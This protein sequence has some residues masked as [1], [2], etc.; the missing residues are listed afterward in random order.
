MRGSWK[1]QIHSCNFLKKFYGSSKQ[2]FSAILN[3]R[4]HSWE[5]IRCVIYPDDIYFLFTLNCVF[6]SGLRVEASWWPRWGDSSWE[7]MK[8]IIHLRWLG[9]WMLLFFSIGDHGRR[10]ILLWG[11]TADDFMR[12]FEDNNSMF[13]GLPRPLVDFIVKRCQ[14]F[15][16]PV[17]SLGFLEMCNQR[18]PRWSLTMIKC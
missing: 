18:S 10:K 8:L 14:L 2:V 11:N 15:E 5:E 9:Y 3:P 1:G 17:L 6:T 12:A 16:P 13:S 4:I 7:A